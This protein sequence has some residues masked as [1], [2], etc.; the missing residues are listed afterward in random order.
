MTDD[1]RTTSSTQ[2]VARCLAVL[3]A[4]AAVIHFDVANMH[5][6]EYWAFG[7]FMVGAALL[8]AAWTGAALLTTKRWLFAT[9]AV[10]NAGIV[11]VYIVTRT[12]GDVV[13]PTPREVEPVGFGD[14][15][16][17]VVE[18]LIAAG[19]IAMLLSRSSRP[20]QQRAASLTL[21]TT[22][23]VMASLLVVALLD[24][25]SEMSMTMG[26]ATINAAP[27]AA[28][29]VTHHKAMPGMKNMSG[30]TMNSSSHHVAK[31]HIKTTSPAG[32]ITTATTMN[33]GAGMRVVSAPCT[34]TPTAAQQAAT[35]RLVN[36]SW[37]DAQRY[38][39][40]AAAKAD[41]YLP[42]TP[43]GLPVV[44]YL[45]LKSYE[46]T[47]RGGPVITP[48]RPESLVY[49]NTPHGAVLAA[50]MYLSRPGTTDPPQPGGCLTPWHIHTNLCYGSF[51][52]IVGETNAAGHC[53]PGT[54]HRI[55]PPMMHVWYVPIPG[56]PT[57]VDA[58]D[59][60][61]VRA[62]EHVRSPH[63]GTA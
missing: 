7:V 47:A 21:G 48:A 34:A 11:A 36:T 2:I 6:Q 13:G 58:S 51:G 43:T 30:M 14:A 9:G 61:I 33:M 20:V 26:D 16:C 56:G 5:Y 42:I 29:H 1:A 62:A 12:V 45:N 46:A 60:Q 27:A 50:T 28:V 53:A 59:A 23:V 40:L 4:V 31:L 19:C 32:D 44:H 49:A 39:S 15:F 38:R 24:G 52:T 41:G 18:A 55:T 25:G 57:A 17:T 37:R 54:I 22:G 35:V 10:L 3:S 63:N 8:Q